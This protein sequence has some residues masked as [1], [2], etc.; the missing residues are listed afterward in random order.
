[1]PTIQPSGNIAVAI[2]D[3]SEN[4]NKAI[5]AIS[6]LAGALADASGAVGAVVGLVQ[7]FINLGKPDEVMV[8]LDAILDAIRDNFHSLNADLAAAQILER[9]TTLKGFFNQAK[10]QL[11]SLQAEINAN[12]TPAQVVD[13]ILPCIKAL[14]DLGSGSPENPDFAWNMDFGW[15]VYWT[16]QGLYILSCLALNQS[17]ETHD[18]GY[19]L[20]APDANPDGVTVFCYTYSLPLYLFA[21]AIFLAVAGSLDP[22]FVLNYRETVLRPSAALLRTKYEKIVQEGLTQ[23]SPS[24]WSSHPEVLSIPC[25][26]AELRDGRLHGIRSVPP[27][28]NFS[29]I[30]L[31]EYG[32]V[33][34]YSGYSSLGNNYRIDAFPSIGPLFDPALLNKL[35]LRLLK[36]KKDVYS[37]VGMPSVWRLI[38][39]LNAL[40]GDAPLP[41]VNQA[42]WSIRECFRVTQFPLVHVV[43]PVSGATNEVSLRAFADFVIQTQPLDTPYSTSAPRNVPISLRQ[44]LTNFSDSFSIDGMPS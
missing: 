7:T 3:I 17:V 33:E 6:E 23:L 5:N 15:Q 25:L 10:A 24:D 8:K 34:K 11:D 28:N 2:N 38:N 44:L 30:H 13:F 32:A 9:N 12:P 40:V 26:T 16:D 37:G 1:M 20:Q 41:Y 19:G 35:Q 39:K 22:H 27:V 43:G 29:T 36:R 4:S 21:V 31:I 14:E 18:V 42:D